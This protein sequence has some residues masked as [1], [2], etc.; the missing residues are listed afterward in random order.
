MQ[1]LCNIWNSPEEKVNLNINPTDEQL[2]LSVVLLPC[3]F[4]RQMS[5]EMPFDPLTFFIEV[6]NIG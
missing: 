4:S 1:N 3:L 5:S 2:L 6:E